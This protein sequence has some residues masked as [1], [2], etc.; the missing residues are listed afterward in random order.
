MCCPS[1]RQF[2]NAVSLFFKMFRVH[3]RVWACSRVGMFVRVWARVRECRTSMR[4][5]TH[6]VGNE[7]AQ[8]AQR[9]LDDCFPN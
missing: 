8:C 2:R 7:T 4:V 5:S 9:T 6:A 3:A 1:N